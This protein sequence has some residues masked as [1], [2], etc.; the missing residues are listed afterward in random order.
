MTSALTGHC[1]CASVRVVR[2][3]MER[4]RNQLPS[5]L[6]QL[7]NLMKRDPAAY[8]EEVC[9]IVVILFCIMLV[10]LCVVYATV[11][12]LSEF[13]GIAS[14]FACTGFTSPV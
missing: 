13:T 7:Q 2:V 12:P 11:Q 8:Q 14:P 9:I 5:N 6:P 3:K 4:H 10:Y 1:A